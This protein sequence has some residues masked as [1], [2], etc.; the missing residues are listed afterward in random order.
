MSEE[1][2]PCPG[3][4]AP[5]SRSIDV[6]AKC[7]RPCSESDFEAARSAALEAKSRR[8][9]RW[10]SAVS[11]LFLPVCA[12][13]LLVRREEL[14][15]LYSSARA[16]VS[17][18]LDEAARPAV[19]GKPLSPEAQALLGA[20]QK[21]TPK[22]AAPEKP[23]AVPLPPAPPAPP[24]AP[25]VARRPPAPP[26]PT[27]Q[28]DGLVRVFGVVYDLDTAA[29]I[30]GAAIRIRGS[31]Q[32]AWGASTDADGFYIIAIPMPYMQEGLTA[33]ITAAGYREGQ[34]EDSPAPY[35]ERPAEVRRA[36]IDQLAPSDLEPLPV[37]SRQSLLPL[38][39]VL[40]PKVLAP[41]KAGGAPAP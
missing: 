6:C 23:A 27:G 11:A 28:A 10:R 14:V 34:L 39:A 37:R 4:A 35:F 21:A 40:V 25:R 24:A 15:S 18:R 16:E 32:D 38:D 19:P 3:C 1:T 22:G 9:R 20:I 13:I 12:A 33:V 8:S 41:V 36:V 2:I 29:P 31:G 30:S 17:R 26:E 7:R 5:L